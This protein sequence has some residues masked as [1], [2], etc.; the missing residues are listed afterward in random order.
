MFEPWE[1]AILYA[2]YAVF[3]T[4]LLYGVVRYLPQHLAFLERRARYYL[5]GE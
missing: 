5:F 2:V 1:V 4:L 3:F